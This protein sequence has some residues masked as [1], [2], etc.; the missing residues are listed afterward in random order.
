M[1]SPIKEAYLKIPAG[2]RTGISSAVKVLITVI[3]FYILFAHKVQMI[4]HRTIS[5]N[6]GESIQAVQG[7]LLKIGN[8]M[9]T[10]VN[11][12]KGRR[13]DGTEVVFR[14][15]T[16]VHLPDGREGRIEALETETTF[17][18][19]I[20]FLPRI[21][22]G[23]F[24]LFVILAAAVKF[25]GIISSM[26]RWHLLLQGQGI[27][28]PFRHLFGSFLIGRFL[29]TFLPSTIG[30][31][32]YK[33]YDASRFS[34]R[35][36]ECTA[37]TVIEKTLGIIGLF[38]TFLV[39]LPFGRTILGKNADR[40]T[41]LTVPLATGVIAGFFLLLFYPAIIQWVINHLPIPG[42]NRIEG[43]INRVNR[44]AAA[45]RN[46]KILLITASAMSFLVH[47]TTAAMYFC[48]ALAIGAAHARFWQVTF[49]S[50][51]QI[52]ATVISPVTVG[53]EGIREIVQYY[54]L[55][56]QLGP[57]ESI[58][59]AALGFWAAEALTL[60]G[61]LFWWIRKK[62]Y[63]PA[64]L[65]LDNTRVDL[66][67]LMSSD[68]YGLEEL[69]PVSDEPHQKGWMK[70][71]VMTRISSGAAG[72]ALAGI[73]LSAGESIWTGLAKGFGS[74]MILYGMIVYGCIGLLFGSGLGCLTGVI[75]VA[76]GRI[77]GSVRTFAVSFAGWLAVNI[78]ILG[79]FLLNRDIFKE[80][81]VP[82]LWLLVLLAAAGTVFLTALWWGQTGKR[83]RDEWGKRSFVHCGLFLCTGALIW[84]IVSLTAGK[85][86]TDLPAAADPGLASGKPNIVLIV[87]DALRADRLG[88]YGYR[89]A[90]TPVIDQL[91]EEGIRF[92]SNY[93]QSSWTKPAV[94]TL[95][96]GM[97][98]S[99]HK[100]YLKPDVLP[101]QVVT[102]PEILRETGYFTAGFPNNINVTSGFNFDQGFDE[103]TY[104]APDYFF[105][106]DEFSS[107][108]TYYSILRKIREGYLVKSKHPR[109]YYQQA[110]VVTRHATSFLDRRDTSRPFFLFLHYMEPH[111]PFFHHPFNGV[112]YARVTMPN[113]DP[114][115]ADL[116]R[117]AY[118]EE[119]NYMD[120]WIGRLFESLKQKKLWD[121]TIIVLT[122]DHGE[123]FYDHGGWWHGLTLYQELIHVP[124]II[125]IN[126]NRA[127]ELVPGVRL[128]N[129]RQ[130]DIAPTLLGLT[131]TPAPDSMQL[132]RNLFAYGENNE[133]DIKVFSEEDHE[134]NVIRSYI[135]GPWKLI[136]ANQGNPRGLAPTELYQLDIDPGELDDLSPEETEV[137]H[138]M[139]E[140]LAVAES[141]AR[142]G[143][144]VRQ[145]KEISDDEL[146]KMRELGYIQ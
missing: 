141:E 118:D 65:Y 9:V 28:F 78:L 72:G 134:G 67:T 74:S 103:F 97:Y 117:Q 101:D 20:S 119:I 83:N 79:R 98:P 116:M 54:L 43:F 57:A 106:A 45:Y 75:A 35:T 1:P 92:Q 44:A 71:A 105:Y 64:Y 66:D 15:G 46:K 25:I 58:V 10:V 82:K 30:L 121:N 126:R 138:R 26:F 144:V 3:A 108:L 127:D 62:N 137:L 135:D 42:K 38:I 99:G 18:A 94:A 133:R 96:T 22:A 40:V 2:I 31:D 87:C 19:I 14:D 41:L 132:G 114:S 33:L 145:E 29:G 37:A 85:R 13:D 76:F 17:R 55:R 77:K 91:A 89:K 139:Q 70:R 110:A 125:K 49:A 69:R 63:R 60:F 95:L 90:R 36:V 21:E 27:R 47:F 24:W 112:G 81:G 123:E 140:S 6:S 88:C 100:T 7:D 131:R 111:D 104:L 122:A 136:R 23:T 73:L 50:S 113:P 59:S 84:I 120:G 12:S 93:A 124:L 129:A 61:A 34:R 5:L 102:L 109:H 4:D 146:Q 32:G 53:G 80:Q 143:E 8:Q 56:N 51:I 48:T 16:T 142:T 39:A 107:K 11:G 128:D 86:Q 52:F 115:M 130:I 68:D